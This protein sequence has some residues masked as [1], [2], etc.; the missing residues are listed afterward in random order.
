MVIKECL[1][2]LFGEQDSERNHRFSGEELFKLNAE[3]QQLPLHCAYGY[4]EHDDCP[5]NYDLFEVKNGQIL[6]TMCRICQMPFG[7]YPGGEWIQWDV[8]IANPPTK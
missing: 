7:R 4:P 1:G 2:Y 6:M 8:L 5:S 3:P